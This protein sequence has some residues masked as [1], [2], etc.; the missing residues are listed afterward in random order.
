MIVTRIIGGLGNQM[1][2]Y[3]AGRSLALA[4]GCQLKLDISGYDNYGLR[5]Y[6]LEIFNIK[7]EVASKKQVLRLSGMQSRLVHFVRRKLTWEKR[8]HFIERN[9]NFNSAFFNMTSPVYLD[10]YWQS[11]KYFESYA[12]QIREELTFVKPI[13]GRNAELAKQISQVNAISIHVRRGDYVSH[14]ATNKVHGFLGIEYYKEAIRRILNEVSAPYFFIFSDDL[15]WAKDN[16]GL[17]D[18]VTFVAHNTGLNSYEDLRLM[19]LCQHHV[20]ANSSFS[21]WAAW[22]GCHPGKKVLY[23][24]KWFATKGKDISS[25]CPPKWSC[26][27]GKE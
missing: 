18:N 22:L 25:L 10:G 16:L 11:Y 3:A 20:I 8:T 15:A 27:G 21:W 17:V 13:V 6:E 7:A 4:N 9:F 2:Q 24:G 26:I 5:A 12:A 23:P 19:S 14:Q 1:F